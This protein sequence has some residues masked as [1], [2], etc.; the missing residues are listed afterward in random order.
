MDCHVEIG[1]PKKL[2]EMCRALSGEIFAKVKAGK[3]VLDE[4][5]LQK[6]LRQQDAIAP[7]LFNMA[8]EMVIR[9]VCR[10]NR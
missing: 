9:N 1:I 2:V 10:H 5:T 8:L 4:F 3:D 7:L 6:G